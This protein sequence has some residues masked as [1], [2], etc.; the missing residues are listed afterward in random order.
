MRA[1]TIM[2]ASWAQTRNA[3]PYDHESFMGADAQCAPLRCGVSCV[4]VTNFIRCECVRDRLAKI[5]TCGA[6]GAAKTAD[7]G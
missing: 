7:G 2:K 5:G 4:T 3:R 6:E 1:P